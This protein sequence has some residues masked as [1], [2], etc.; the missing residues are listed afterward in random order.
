M[1]RIAIGVVVGALCFGTS[2]AGARLANVTNPMGTSLDGGGNDITHV[3]YYQ[4]IDTDLGAVHARE[5]FYTGS[6][7]ASH[8]NL[9]GDKGFVDVSAGTD[10]PVSGTPGLY[11]QDLG[12]GSVALWVKTTAGWT[13]VAG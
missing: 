10:E 3:R 1:R 5:G 9:T 6:V 2:F 8:I 13:K 12:R 4:G 11:L 7:S